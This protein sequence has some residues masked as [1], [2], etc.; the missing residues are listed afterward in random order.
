MKL[1]ASQE[2]SYFTLQPASI[3]QKKK[4]TTNGHPRNAKSKCYLTYA[5]RSLPRTMKATVKS[6]QYLLLLCGQFLPVCLR[7]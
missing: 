7:N 5:T 4:L 2:C 1:L 3:R 6:D